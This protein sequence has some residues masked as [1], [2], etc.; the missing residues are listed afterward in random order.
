MA[1]LAPQFDEVLKNIEPSRQDNENAP[2]AHLEVRRVL[3]ADEKLVGYG[4]DTVLIGSYPRHVSIRRIR[5]VDVFSKL[6]NLPENVGPRD[7][8]KIFADVLTAGLNEERVIPNDRSIEVHFPDF[9]LYVDVVP[10][11]SCGDHW[12]IPDRTDRGG[13]WQETNPERLIEL[14][15]EMNET[16]HDL[17]VP[18]VKLVRQT[19]RANLR[20]QPPGYYFEVLTYHAFASGAAT[21]RNI[22]EY[23]CSALRGVVEQLESAIEYGLVDPAMERPIVPTRA[24]EAE[25]LGALD[26]F[27]SLADKAE[28]A[29]MDDDRCAAAKIFRELLGRNTDDEVV[30]PMPEDCNQDGT[31]KAAAVVAGDRRVP[32]GDR[33]FA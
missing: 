17:Y 7:L 12:E 14:T 18:T 26:T 3:E 13:G 5:D 11:R 24:S 4:I 30:F 21:G 22:A 20:K 2:Q 9:D 8:H 6:P 27:R 15:V 16:H 10:A 29:L 28:A 25:L 32:A 33:R 31:R 23:Y 1:L 19:R